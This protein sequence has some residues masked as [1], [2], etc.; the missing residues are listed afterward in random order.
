[1][2]SQSVKK[3]IASLK[4]GDTFYV[5]EN[6]KT[7][8]VDYISGWAIFKIITPNDEITVNCSTT[9]YVRKPKGKHIH[10]V[11]GYVTIDG[12]ECC[13]GVDYENVKI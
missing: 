12:E 4:K 11:S 8:A 10:F 9:P 3:K 5:K 2:V 13:C 1:M 6:Q 7:Y